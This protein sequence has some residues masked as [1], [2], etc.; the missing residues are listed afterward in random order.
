M[1]VVREPCRGKSDIIRRMRG[2]RDQVVHSIH[3]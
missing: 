1:K 2:R 3:V